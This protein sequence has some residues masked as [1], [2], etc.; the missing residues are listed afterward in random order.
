MTDKEYEHY[1]RYFDSIRKW[2]NAKYKGRANPGFAKGGFDEYARK[3]KYSA[4]GGQ[5]RT[6]NPHEGYFGRSPLHDMYDQACKAAAQD[7]L[8]IIDR[9]KQVTKPV[10]TAVFEEAIVL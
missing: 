10:N 6:Y 1:Q 5:F 3:T 9:G 2:L 8:V 7:K 4:H